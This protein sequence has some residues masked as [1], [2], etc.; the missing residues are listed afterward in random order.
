MNC[1]HFNK[2][3]FKPEII[4]KALKNYDKEKGYCSECKAETDSRWICLACAK[5]SCGRFEKGH[6]LEHFKSS[7]HTVALDLESKACH[8]YLCDEYIHAGDLEDELDQLRKTVTDMISGIDPKAHTPPIQVHFLQPLISPMTPRPSSS[9][10]TTRSSSNSDIVLWSEVSDILLK[11][12]E[13]KDTV[14]S[15]EDFLN[16]MR[17]VLPNYKGY[18]QQDAQEF[19]R[20]LLDKMHEELETRK[21]RTM[22]MQ[23]FQGMF[24]NQISCKTCENKSIKE[25]PYLDLSLSIPDIPNC[26]IID[27]LNSFT[28]LEDLTNSEKYNCTICNSLQPATKRLLIS[29]IPPILCLHLKRFK[30]VNNTRSKIDTHVS[31]PMILDVS[32]FQKDEQAK[33]NLYGVIV[34][35]GTSAQG[36]YVA[37]VMHNQIWYEMNDRITKQVEF[38]QVA[39]EPAYMLFYE[40]SYKR[41]QT[42]ITLSKELSKKKI[43]Q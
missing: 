16:S 24:I 39:N 26:T 14:I 34:H 28:A 19:M 30:Y 9:G 11:L 25:E 12:W 23:L 33:Y 1:S 7:T 36:H 29:R 10:R 35:R 8:C 13:T 37:Y 22:I 43:K 27:C 21:G 17:K 2:T 18:Q 41:N 5:I 6:A 38:T 4:Q 31:F 42:T 20:E 15:P 40:R 32:K 3:N